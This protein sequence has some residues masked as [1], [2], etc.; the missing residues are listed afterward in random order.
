MNERAT[1]INSFYIILSKENVEESI[2]FQGWEDGKVNC[3]FDCT[4]IDCG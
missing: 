4:L 1:F 2:A 3:A